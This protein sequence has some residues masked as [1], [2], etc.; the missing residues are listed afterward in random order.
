MKS[1]AKYA[2]CMTQI[3]YTVHTCTM[4]G[5]SQMQAVVWHAGTLMFINVYVMDT[6][7]D[8]GCRLFGAT[9]RTHS[10]EEL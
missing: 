6:F 9:V 10:E 3:E 1:L 5:V 7:M 2:Q 8:L 4:T